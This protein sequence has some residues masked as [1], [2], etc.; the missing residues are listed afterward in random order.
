VDVRGHLEIQG[1]GRV[2]FGDDCVVEGNSLIRTGGADAIVHIGRA[3][4]LSDVHIDITGEVVFGENI[5]VRGP[6][7]IDGPGRVRIGDGC[8]VDRASGGNAIHAVRSIAVVTIGRECYLNGIDVF[9]TEDVTI[10]DRCIIGESS[11]VTT[12]FHSANADRWSPHAV[13]RTGAIVVGSNVWI[14][15]RTVITK[16][17]S[18][19][20]NSV[21]SIGT[22]VREDV[23]S[24]VIVSSHEQRV[25]KSLHGPES[26]DP[27][28][29]P[30]WWARPNTE[31]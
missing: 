24:G 29:W 20:A 27:F 5:D 9:A 7:V 3:C 14:A 26:P 12:D 21:V 25:V 10:G 1:S 15:S 18:I 13:V 28:A 2:E 17:V 4:H 6:L 11:F 23:P 19:G 30:T 31:G 8:L 16:G 22:I